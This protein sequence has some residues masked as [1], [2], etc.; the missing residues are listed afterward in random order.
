MPHGAARAH[1][2]ATEIRASYTAIVEGGDPDPSE[3]SDR[4]WSSKSTM[5]PGA[6]PV[7]PDPQN[8]PL[9]GTSGRLRAPESWSLH[10]H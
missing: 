10:W 3:M 4:I 1:Q 6:V 8:A 5:L 2:H 7:V 9:G